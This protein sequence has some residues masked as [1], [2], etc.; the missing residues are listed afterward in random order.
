MVRRVVDRFIQWLPSG[1]DRRV[2]VAAWLSLAFQ[3]ALIATGGAVRLT[4]SG[5]GCPTWPQCTDGSFIATPEMGIHGFIEFGNRLLTFV[6]AAITIAAFL[7]VVRFRRQRRD[8]FRLTLVQGLS[9]PFQAVL[10]GITV[11]TGLNPYVVGAH[12]AVSIVLVAVTTT[13]VWRV[14]NGPRGLSS[15]VP[16]WVV[17]L[18]RLAAVFVAVTVVVGILTTGSGPHAGDNSD[19]AKPAPRNG[20]DPVLLQHVHSWPAYVTLGLSVL[21]AIVVL[22]FP[23]ERRWVLALVAVEVAQMIVGLTQARLGLPE[24]LVGIHMVL[25]GA[26]VAAMTAVLLS[27][28]GNLID[29]AKADPVNAVER[30]PAV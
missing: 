15:L 3:V 2:R 21:L 1:V 14:Y 5:L 13:L 6:L 11:L 17:L 27:L 30:V 4:A 18:G 9:I 25:A 23:V 10:G 8:L 20:L 19:P 28:R 24:L 16:S 22:R 12:F 29:A 7:S 26:L